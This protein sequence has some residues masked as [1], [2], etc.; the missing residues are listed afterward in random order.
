MAG[1]GPEQ[2]WQGMC[3]AGGCVN[4]QQRLPTWLMILAQRVLHPT[5]RSL[6]YGTCCTTHH[7]CSVSG[8]QVPYCTAGHSK[9]I[10][11]AC[12]PLFLFLNQH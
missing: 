7:H 12:F 10:V 3:S 2:Q 1:G 9:C 11:L 4:Q 8:H 5:S 6:R